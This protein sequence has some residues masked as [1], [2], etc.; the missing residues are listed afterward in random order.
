MRNVW[1]V[2]FAICTCAASVYAQDFPES[3]SAGTKDFTASIGVPK[4]SSAS[5][6]FGELRAPTLTSEAA[7]FAPHRPSEAS[8][9]AAQPDPG[10]AAP[11]PKFVF[12]ARDDYRWQLGLGISLVRFR[13]SRFYAT[14]V[15][16]ST[17]LAYFTNE[18]LAIQGEVTT[19]FAPTIYLNE[20]VKYVSYGAGPMVAWRQRKIEPWMHA[21]FGGLHVQPQTAGSGRNAFG[22]QVG[23]GADYRFYPHLSARVELDWVRSHLFSQWQDSAQAALELVLHF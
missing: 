15:G 2:L 6:L 11:E 21:I 19:A 7:M 8:A 1:I 18:W 3:V 16:T 5:P 9:F 22:I 12:G 4:T 23:G 17:S 13:S 14:G 20:H 10:A